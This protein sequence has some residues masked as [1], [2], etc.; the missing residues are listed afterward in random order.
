MHTKYHKIITRSCF[1][2]WFTEIALQ[3]IIKAN[4]TQ[5]K[6]RYQ[7]GHDYIHFDGSAFEAGFKYIDNQFH[8][9]YESIKKTRY[10]QAWDALGHISHS[11]QD[12]YS[13]SNYVLLWINKYNT[14]DPQNIS[15]NDEFIM[16]HKNL[17][18]GKNYGLIEFVAL[19]PVIKR[20]ILPLMPEDSHAKMNLDGPHADPL[21]SFALIAAK[22]RTSMIRNSIQSKLVDDKI[23]AFKIN[24]F[25]GYAQVEERYNQTYE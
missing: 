4:I 20:L 5:D 24:S 22:K 17:T 18:S 7:F 15:P 21:F 12:F 6:P 13:H 2:D 14:A 16:N 8:S 23:D 1:E 3:A 9:L 25:R 19:L 10:Q 11:W